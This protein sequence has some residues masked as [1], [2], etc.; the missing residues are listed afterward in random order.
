M[1]GRDHPRFALKLPFLRPLP[2]TRVTHVSAMSW[3]VWVATGAAARVADAD[4]HD[5]PS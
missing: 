2:Q 1:H 3:T 5:C 4:S